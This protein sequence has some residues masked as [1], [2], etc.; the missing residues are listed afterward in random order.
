MFGEQ[1]QSFSKIFWLLDAMDAKLDRLV[2]RLIGSFSSVA[3]IQLPATTTNQPHTDYVTTNLP[4]PPV[5]LIQPQS[6]IESE[7]GPDLFFTNDNMTDDGNRTTISV[8]Q[9]LPDNFPQLQPNVDLLCKKNLL[10]GLGH[11]AINARDDKDGDASGTLLKSGIALIVVLESA[12]AHH[13]RPTDSQLLSS[14]PLHIWVGVA[15]ISKSIILIT[16][17]SYFVCNT[18]SVNV[19]KNGY[20]SNLEIHLPKIS[21][22]DQVAVESQGEREKKVW[23]FFAGDLLADLFTDLLANLF[24]E[25]PLPQAA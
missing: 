9:P 20:T 11:T 14:N 6:E 5:P 15:S 21:F 12:A 7:T 18:S 22:S 13:P 3:S 4:Q 19:S 24:D 17:P 23:H 1:Q 8:L 25:L 2:P 10:L 16:V